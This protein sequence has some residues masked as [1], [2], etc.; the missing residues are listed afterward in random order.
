MLASRFRVLCA[1]AGLSVDEAAKLLHVTPRTV[2]YWISGKVSIPYA[3]YKLV[4]VMRWFE[5]PGKDWAGWHF[6]SN[7]LWSPEGHGFEAK[8]SSWWSLLVNRSRLFGQLAERE[9][10]FLHAIGAGRDAAPGLGT[11]WRHRDGSGQT[12]PTG[13]DGR[14]AQPPRLNLS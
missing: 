9:R 5:L 11:P 10:A 6:H 7:R 1:E 4:R 14:A 3:A 2:R 8:D 13:E 12:E